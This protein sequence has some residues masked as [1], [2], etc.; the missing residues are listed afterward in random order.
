MKHEIRVG[1]T[2]IGAMLLIYSI[3]TWAKRMHFFSPEEV[4]YNMVFDN[5]SGLLEG[6]PVTVRGYTAGR[7]IDILPE[8]EGVRVRISLDQQIR[9][10]SDVYGEIQIKELM[11][12]K[13]M[14][15]FQ[16]K[17]GREY[18]ASAPIPGRTSMDFSSAFSRMGELMNE[19][20]T[21][22]LRMLLH[23]LDTFSRSMS[24][25]GRQIDTR[26]VMA[27]PGQLSRTLGQAENLLTQVSRQDLA[28]Q[29]GHTLSR[30]DSLLLAANRLLTRFDTLTESAATTTL[31]QVD[32]LMQQTLHLLDRS[33]VMLQTAESLFQD[34]K[35][36]ES[37]AGKMLY[38]PAFAHRVD[39]TLKHLDDVLLQIRE[40][41]IYVAIKVGKRR[42]K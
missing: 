21:D 11:G 6:D 4:Y 32:S 17:S 22:N 23:T 35:N 30:S 20:D 29:V 33:E 9:L 38:D 34:L 19:L 3:I 5:V 14:A 2:V 13:Q 24:D 15:L 18:D 16:G 8:P 36:E 25:L 39:S 42:K 26:M 40:D 27:L 37:F 1:L 28:G 31:P 41:K 7:V 12:G 10:Q